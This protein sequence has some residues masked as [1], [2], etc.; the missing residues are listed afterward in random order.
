[1]FVGLLEAGV[2]RFFVDLGQLDHIDSTGLAALLQLCREAR[3]RGG[4][5]WLFNPTPAV[6]NIFELTNLRKVLRI[7][8]TREAAFA[9]A[10]EPSP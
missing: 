2:T 8:P 5:V 1:M 3:S 6:L 7:V 10:E 9:E 4:I